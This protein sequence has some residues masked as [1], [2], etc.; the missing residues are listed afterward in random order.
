MPKNAL[1]V[2]QQH[3]GND[4]K[5]D[6]LYQNKT[7]NTEARI[8]VPVPLKRLLSFLRQLAARHL[9]EGAWITPHQLA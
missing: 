4:I 5:F 3:R 9:D 1:K 2:Y 6:G 7:Q 8:N